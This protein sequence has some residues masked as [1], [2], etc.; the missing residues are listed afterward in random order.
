MFCL[1]NKFILTLRTAVMLLRLQNTLGVCN[2]QTDSARGEGIVSS[3]QWLWGGRKGQ[4]L[5]FVVSSSS[6][7]SPD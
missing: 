3:G 5:E 6:E 1:L 2:L 4:G 7:V